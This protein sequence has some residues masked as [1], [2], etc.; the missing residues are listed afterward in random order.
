L[1][2]WLKVEVERLGVDIRLNTEATVASIKA[3]DADVV[4]V[5]TGAVRDRPSV[6]GGD[7]PHVHTGDTLRAL[8]TGAGDTSQVPHFLRSMAKLGKLSGITK[9]P[10]AIRTVTRKFLPMGK[11]VVVIGGSLVGLELSEF[12]AERGRNVTLVE[13]GQQLGV[14]M[15]M[16]RRWTAVRHA[17][18]MG[19]TIHRNATV[20]RITK[21]HVEFR[22][23]D[24]TLTAPADMVVVASGVSAQAPLA[25]ALVGVVSNVQ[26]VGDAVEVD[27]IEG[28]IHTAWKVATTL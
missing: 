24:K 2:K 3:L 28:A 26:V 11:N 23:G 21:E 5:A 15:A 19:V 13:E 7:L 6:P 22:V 20:Q 18:E 9:S 10:A 27:Y 8:M 4:V 12:L 17:N 25:D 14:P 1:L 16:P